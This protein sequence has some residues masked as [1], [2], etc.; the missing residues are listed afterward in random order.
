MDAPSHSCRVEPPDLA[1]RLR[2]RARRLTGPRQAIFDLLR[3]QGH[4]LTIKEIFGAFPA[5]TCDLVTVYR[6]M[7]LLEEMRVVKRID[8]GDGVARYELL[9]DE[10]DDHH[11]HLVCT[12][13]AAV[14]KVEDCFPAALQEEIAARNGFT[15]V[16]HRL[17][18]FGVCPQCQPRR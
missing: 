13:C 14:V 4:P 7:H 6:C 3:G 2:R 5:Q 1:E 11:H 16:S 15:G 8:F 10:E 9:G 12:H 17:E 18:F